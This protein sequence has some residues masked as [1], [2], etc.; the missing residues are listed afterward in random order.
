MNGLGGD[1]MVMKGIHHFLLFI[2]EPVDHRCLCSW[3]S[4]VMP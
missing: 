3:F 4:P 1:G 2:D